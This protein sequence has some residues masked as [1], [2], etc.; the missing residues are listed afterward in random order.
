MEEHST[1]RWWWIQLCPFKQ[2]RQETTDREA[3]NW[4]NACWFSGGLWDYRKC[5]RCQRFQRNLRPV[6]GHV[7]LKRTNARLFAFG[8]TQPQS[9]QGKFD[10]LIEL[11]PELTSGNTSLLRYATSADL[12]LIT[13]HW[14]PLDWAAKSNRQRAT[15][16]RERMQDSRPSV[17]R[18]LTN[19]SVGLTTSQK[20]HAILR[21]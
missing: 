14:T 13:L 6:N 10:T 12:G 4:R 19:E 20:K 15:D 5:S 17:T 7:P 8:S 1:E 16:N 11:N 9:L 18:S 2:H 21:A 3:H